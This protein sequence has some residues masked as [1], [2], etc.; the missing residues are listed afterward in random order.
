MELESLYT[1][2]TASQQEPVRLDL[3]LRAFFDETDDGRRAVYERYLRRRLRPALAALVSADDT[4]RLEKIAALGWLEE[5]A[6]ESALALAQREGKTAA[7][8]FL[9][10]WK[11]EHYGYRD[12]DFSL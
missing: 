11:G 10:R 9:L 1:A 6:V 5:G 2:F 12:W 8:V 3:A 4:E 7:L